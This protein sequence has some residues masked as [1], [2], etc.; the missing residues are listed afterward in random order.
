MGQFGTNMAKPELL[1]EQIPGR[2]YIHNVHACDC[3]VKR[4]FIPLRI[5]QRIV[6]MLKFMGFTVFEEEEKY[7]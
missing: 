5:P 2:S 6:S 3:L 4:P 1:V 7:I